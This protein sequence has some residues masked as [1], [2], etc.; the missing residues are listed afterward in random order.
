MAA[1][2]IDS[3][4]ELRKTPPLTPP[5]TPT[6]P[7][8]PTLRRRSSPTIPA[9]TASVQSL[10]AAIQGPSRLSAA[11]LRASAA[12]S[13]LALQT[14]AAQPVDRLVLLKRHRKRSTASE[15]TIVVGAP[16]AVV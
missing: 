8:T 11:G 2:A 10:N 4:E 14:T 7:A 12:A 13:S 15:K 9:F 6:A 3:S 5:S 1:P 16:E